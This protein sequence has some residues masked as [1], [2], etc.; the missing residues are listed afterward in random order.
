MGAE[1]IG[2][3]SFQF[4]WYC[5]DSAQNRKIFG[6][7]LSMTGF[8]L[9]V[10]QGVLEGRLFDQVSQSGT[11]QLQA[12]KWYLIQINTQMVGGWNPLSGPNGAYEYWL[13]MEIYLG[14]TLELS[15]VPEA[16]LSPPVQGGIPG[17]S[18]LV[19]LNGM[20][21]DGFDEIRSLTRWLYSSEIVNYAT[22]LKAG[23]VPG[24]SQGSLGSPGW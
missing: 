13:T 9:K 23:R 14:K 20:R 10:N 15:V 11:T 2:Y 3:R 19:S 22:F 16:P 24:K 6:Y 4:L 21:Y 5:S 18:N 7:S 12:E 8:A 1:P 17:V